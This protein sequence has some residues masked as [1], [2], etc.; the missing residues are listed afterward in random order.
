MAEEGFRVMS[1]LSTVAIN[2]DHDRELLR[3]LGGGLVQT[4]V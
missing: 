1:Q 4:E 2:E 3:T